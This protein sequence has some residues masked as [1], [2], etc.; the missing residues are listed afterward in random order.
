M[1]LIQIEMEIAEH[2]TMEAVLCF[3]KAVMTE[4]QE[5]VMY[6]YPRRIFR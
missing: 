4:F 1:A 6:G 5:S 3:L 2:A